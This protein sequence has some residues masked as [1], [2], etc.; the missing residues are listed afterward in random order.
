MKKGESSPG[1]KDNRDTLQRSDSDDNA[2]LICAEH[3]QMHRTD[4]VDA[5]ATE[6]QLSNAGKPKIFGGKCNV[7]AVTVERIG[8]REGIK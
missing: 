5:N 3:C 4:T 7:Q 6:H 1:P 2:P 8:W